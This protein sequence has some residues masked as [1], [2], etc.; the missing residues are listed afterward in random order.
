MQEKHIPLMQGEV[1]INKN[2]PW[3][4]FDVASWGNPSKGGSRGILYLYS[5]HNISFKE[6]IGQETNKFC[7]MMAL[8]L[9]LKLAQEFGVTQLQIC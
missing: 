8:K 2:I 7:E 9:V 4:F 6:K 3:D 1:A 5:D